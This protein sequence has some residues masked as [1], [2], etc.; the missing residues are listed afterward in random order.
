MGSKDSLEK[1]G[2]GFS[3]LRQGSVILVFL[4]VVAAGVYEYVIARP[5]FNGMAITLNELADHPDGVSNKSS[6]S[7]R[8]RLDREPTETKFMQNDKL[9]VERYS[10]P[11]GLPF[12]KFDLY[13]WYQKGVG[14]TEWLYSGH[15]TKTPPE[16]TDFRPGNDI[17]ISQNK[18]LVIQFGGNLAPT[19]P[20]PYEVPTENKD[21]EQKV[22]EPAQGNRS[23]SK[24]D[25]AESS[26]ADDKPVNR[27]Q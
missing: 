16:K 6:E 13:V 22:T 19:R 17:V 14:G 11:R 20:S 26:P 1:R 25:A 23:D 8:E 18:N 21:E 9:M 2:A 4:L 15:K 5:T 7:I 10:V 27:K 3:W 24:D 12:A